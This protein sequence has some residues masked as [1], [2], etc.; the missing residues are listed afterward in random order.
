MALT[1]ASFPLQFKLS[2]F[3]AGLAE[4]RVRFWA[5][6]AGP[7]L[8][9]AG[10]IADSTTLN[11]AKTAGLAPARYLSDNNAYAFFEALG[12]LIHTGPTGTNVGDLQVILLA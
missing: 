9:A 5:T 10:A 6:L 11:R 8:D 1:L 12:D 4:E 2:G 7:W 3:G